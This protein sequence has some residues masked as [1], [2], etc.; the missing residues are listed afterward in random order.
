MQCWLLTEHM[1]SEKE[2][3]QKKSKQK[4]SKQKKSKQKVNNRKVIER[5]VS[6]YFQKTSKRNLIFSPQ[7]LRMNLKIFQILITILTDMKSSSQVPLIRD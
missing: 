6:M 3:K 1:E 2:S 7:T 4:K 5:K